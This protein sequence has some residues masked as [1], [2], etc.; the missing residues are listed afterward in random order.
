MEANLD[1]AQAQ[2]DEA[3]KT[4]GV[5]GAENEAAVV[6][7]SGDG[8]AASNSSAAADSIAAA[9]SI[10]VLETYLQNFNQELSSTTTAPAAPAASGDTQSQDQLEQVAAVAVTLSELPE[11]VALQHQQQQQLEM[12]QPV[13]EASVPKEQMVQPAAVEAIEGQQEFVAAQGIT[14]GQPQHISA[15]EPT[16]VS[17]TQSQEV[18]PQQLVEVVQH[19]AEEVHMESTTSGED[20]AAMDITQ[21]LQLLANASANI[22]TQPVVS[23]DVSAQQSKPVVTVADPSD[24]MGQAFIQGIEGAGLAGQQN[25]TIQGIEGLQN[26]EGEQ[27]V[28]VQHVDQ[29][30]NM[31]QQQQQV[32]MVA[33]QNDGNTGQ[34]VSVVGNSIVYENSQGQQFIPVSQDGTQIAF[35][36]PV[37]TEVTSNNTQVYT[38]VQGEGADQSGVE[39]SQAGTV[40]AQEGPVVSQSSTEVVQEAG[41]VPAAEPTQEEL[42]EQAVANA[43][44]IQEGSVPPSYQNKEKVIT[45]RRSPRK[46]QQVDVEGVE[47][48][49]VVVGEDH[50]EV[51]VPMNTQIV[52]VREVVEGEDGE[53]TIQDHSVYDFYA[54]DNDDEP[55]TK[56]SLDDKDSPKKRKKYMVP[57]F[58]DGRLIDQ[59][60][61][62]AKKTPASPREPKVHECNKCGRIFRTSTLL[63][64]HLN[65]HSG[66]K[67]YKCELCEKAFGTSGELGRHMKY[68]HTH[69]KPHKCPLCEYYSVEASKIKRH[70]RSH[71]GE[72]P[73][74]CTLCDY[75]STDNYKLKRHM[76]V[77]TGEKPFQCGECE[78]SFSQK[79]SLKEHLWKHAGSRPAHK[80][81]YCDTTFGRHAD[82]KTHIRKMHTQGQPLICKICENGFTDRF[83]FMQ[84]QKTHKGEKIYQCLECEYS[85]PQKRHLVVH[86]RVHTG[87]RPFQCTDCQ[88][89]FKH[90]Q[91]LVNHLQKKHDIQPEPEEASQVGLKRKRRDSSEV[92]SPSKKVT[93]RQKMALPEQQ[94]QIVDEHGNTLQ[95]SQEDAEA[96][97]AAMQQGTADGTLQI[98]QGEEGGPVTVLTVAQNPDGT[99]ANLEQNLQIV[100]G[101]LTTVQQQEQP[102]T[103]M[104]GD[105]LPSQVLMQ[106]G[107]EDQP[108]TSQEA[109]GTSQPAEE[110]TENQAET[111]PVKL[112]TEKT[113]QTPQKAPEGSAEQETDSD[114]GLPTMVQPQ[115]KVEGQKAQPEAE[116]EP[117]VITQAESIL[118]PANQPISQNQEEEDDEEVADDGTIY[119]FVEEQ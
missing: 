56:P 26:M 112:K 105:I 70:M 104:A 90:K 34:P 81:E 95:L 99:V 65:T 55:V 21:T 10:N 24:T 33:M 17:I 88:E 91:T 42:E 16:P 71:T 5:N 119:L 32:L 84:H 114:D 58:D 72:K 36:Q 8:V 47:G 73:Y 66:T 25:I 68:M 29:H 22:A 102:E 44:A 75:A 76:R 87:E 49:S 39:V 109:E 118:V 6:A 40:V 11:Q 54:G 31:V 63:R 108:T 62:R 85:A 51:V 103:S 28:M 64:N 77:H 67:P 107:G 38:I 115:L 79:S 96:I 1:E 69:E 92:G 113:E 98:I 82:M 12:V 20:A 50:E 2:A 27:M 80:C 48:E 60:L 106:V 14:I 41:E 116:S 93:R 86:M 30:G 59:V 7:E 89:T 53:R 3:V 18:L 45:I 9:A 61:G 35:T 13:A 110:G 97:Q 117:N 100:N 46:R 83:S 4:P 94:H 101:S 23:Q 19:G 78:H 74:R 37:S 52:I 57:K 15:E 111:T 43:A